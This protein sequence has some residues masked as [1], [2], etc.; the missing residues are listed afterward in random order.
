MT[1]SEKQT[2]EL[3]DNI[4]KTYEPCATHKKVKKKF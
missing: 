1:G 3:I 4:M 2:D